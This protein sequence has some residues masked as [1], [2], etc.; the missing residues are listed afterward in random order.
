[1][2]EHTEALENLLP[3]AHNLTQ[4]PLPPE[5]LLQQGPPLRNLL[6][7]QIVPPLFDCAVPTMLEST[8]RKISV[9]TN[10]HR[11]RRLKCP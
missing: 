7:H 6:P 8:I 5:N 9:H 4:I 2:I 10:V 3:N 11:Y 1:M